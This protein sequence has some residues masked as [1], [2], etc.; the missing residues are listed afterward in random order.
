MLIAKNADGD[1]LELLGY[2][3]V[4]GAKYWRFLIKYNGQREF[5]SGN[6]YESKELALNDARAFALSPLCG[7]FKDSD[8]VAGIPDNSVLKVT[9]E[10]KTALNIA[11]QTLQDGSE[12]QKIAAFYIKQLIDKLN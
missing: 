3:R 7:C 2:L 1:K 9:S 8:I 6:V 11:Y 10:Q 4:N 5:N 12:Q